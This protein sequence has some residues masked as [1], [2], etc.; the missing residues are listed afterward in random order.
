MSLP[1]PLLVFGL[2]FLALAVYTHRVQRRLFRAEREIEILVW[3]LDGVFRATRSI[4]DL[5]RVVASMRRHTSLGASVFDRLLVALGFPLLDGTGTRAIQAA[6]VGQRARRRKQAER[7]AAKKKA[8]GAMSFCVRFR[9]ARHTGRDA[10]GPYARDPDPAGSP[11]FLAKGWRRNAAA[12]DQEELIWSCPTRA[13]AGMAAR[14]PRVHDFASRRGYVV[15][16]VSSRFAVR[17]CVEAAA[18]Q[19]GTESREAGAA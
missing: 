9:K 4:L 5:G 14:S 6:K 1:V 17:A 16:V 19:R 2:L 7:T 3:T 10:R 11:L 15:D 18:T 12:T 13:G 8:G